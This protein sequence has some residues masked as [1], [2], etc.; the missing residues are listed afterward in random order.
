VV[1]WRNT[2]PA[3]DVCIDD[4]RFEN[5]AAMVKAN[6]GILIRL[7]RPDVVAG[8]THASEVEQASI[9]ADYVVE[10]EEGDLQ[11]LYK[12]INDIYEKESRV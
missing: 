7:T 10:C 12:Q 4:V 2:L 9:E 6:G 5:E 1:E 3:G 8:D 11:S